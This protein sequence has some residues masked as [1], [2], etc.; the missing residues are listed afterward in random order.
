M[1]YNRV[2]VDTVRK[3]NQ[4]SLT[5]TPQDRQF[6]LDALRAFSVL[7]IVGFWHIRTYV[8]DLMFLK[9]QSTVLLTACILGLFTFLSGYLLSRRAR[10]RSVRDV[11][12][13]YFRRLVRI[14]PLYLAALSVFLALKL[15]STADYVRSALLLNTLLNIPLQTLWFISTIFVLYLLMPALVHR[16]SVVKT[17]LLTSLL[18]GILMVIHHTTDLVDERLPQYLVAFAA[19]ILIAKRPDVESWLREPLASGTGLLVLVATFTLYPQ[20]GGVLKVAVADATILA[21]IPLFLHFGRLLD[22][23]IPRSIVRFGS[24]TSFVAYLL[25]RISF[26]L[27]AQLY[28]PSST[29]PAL[30]YFECGILPATFLAAYIIQKGYNWILRTTGLARSPQPK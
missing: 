15:V 1:V 10:F 26:H 25:H 4:T 13:F 3:T 22:R 27:G 2:T 20:A 19:G 29:V 18:W 7:Y 16:F 5:M 17:L 14:Y 28:R 6:D 12:S 11:G 9:T 24:Y 21:T 30:L 8:P 23:W